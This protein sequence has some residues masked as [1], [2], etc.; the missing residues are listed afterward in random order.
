MGKVFN[1]ILLGIILVV[2]APIVV[3]AEVEVKKIGDTVYTI[4]NKKVEDYMCD[5]VKGHKLYVNYYGDYNK[6]QVY[7]MTTTK[8]YLLDLLNPGVCNEISEDIN[9]DF[10]HYDYRYENNKLYFDTYSIDMEW[11]FIKTTNQELGDGRYYVKED[12]GDFYYVSEPNLVDIG[13][14]YENLKYEPARGEYDSSNDYYV[15]V[16]PNANMEEVTLVLDENKKEEEFNNGQYY[17][18][19]TPTNSEL[20]VTIT[21]SEFV[22]DKDLV[23]LDNDFVGSKDNFLYH[24]V[25]D[26]KPYLVFIDFASQIRFVFDEAGNYQTFG[27]D[28]I[29]V[30]DVTDSRDGKYVYLVAEIDNEEYHLVL[31]SGDKEVL[32]IKKES[33]LDYISFAGN[34]DNKRFLLFGEMCEEIIEINEYTLISGANQKFESKD[35]VFK[36]SG[37]INKLVTVKVNDEVL[38]NK[39]YEQVEGSTVITLKKSY[40]ETLKKGTYALKVEYDDGGYSTVDFEITKTL[41][42]NPKTSD[43]INNSFIVMGLSLI[44]LIVSSIYFKKRNILN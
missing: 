43:G 34:K 2:L 8:M 40:L 10:P 30:K 9:L 39:H 14:Y 36:F 31:D 21:A 38:E 6:V 23:G 28:N 5:D 16:D 1:I 7:D 4:N 25:Y 33:S 32:S 35:L 3:N 12:D 15:I 24:I 42:S 27:Y 37:D 29:K 13:T 26:G 18:V 44:S 41:P 17:V 11:Y 20:I 22:V 19:S